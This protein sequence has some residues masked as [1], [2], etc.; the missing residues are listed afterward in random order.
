MEEKR[1]PLAEK[2]FSAALE[3]EPDDAKTHYLLARAYAEDNKPDL[4]RS[5]IETALRLRPNQP[6][7]IELRD[8]LAAPST[9]AVPQ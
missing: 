3:S 5:E 8:N 6:Q 9:K 7:F 2:F 4:A 1:W